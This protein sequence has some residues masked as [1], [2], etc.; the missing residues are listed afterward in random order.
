MPLI[1]LLMTAATVA[2]AGIGGL[3][4]SYACSVM[5]GLRAVDDATFVNAMTRINTAIQ[6]PV[7]ALSFAGAFVA[8]AGASACS[9]LNGLNSALPAS[10]ALACYTATLL[11]TFG[12][13]IPFEQRPGTCRTGGKCR[14]GQKILR[15]PLDPLERPPH[16]AVAAGPCGAQYCVGFP[17]APLRLLLPEI[18]QRSVNPAAFNYQHEFRQP[19]DQTEQSGVTA[20]TRRSP[21]ISLHFSLAPGVRKGIGTNWTGVPVRSPGPESPK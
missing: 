20:M 1:T 8:L 3:Y 4:Y 17:G 14:G 11:I 12:K 15:T 2:L 13:S 21:A 7:F 18:E 6:N 5:P 9:W 16:V 10:V 19:P